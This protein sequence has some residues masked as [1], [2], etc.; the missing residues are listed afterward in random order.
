M[1]HHWSEYVAAGDAPADDDD[2]VIAANVAR[3]RKAQRMSQDALGAAMRDAG[4]AHWR[5][6][7]VSRVENGRQRLTAGEV[8][9]LQQV[10]GPDVIGNTS[11]L[12]DLQAA[13][14]HV[15][16]LAARKALADAERALAQAL[17]T[18]RELRALY[19][20]EDKDNDHGK[21]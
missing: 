3:L 21:H 11:M 17:A 4:Q 16:D 20:D 7:T 19:D 9:A 13:H 1:E 5:Q 14:P 8:L 10:L 6:T 15:R 18:V 12:A 2:R